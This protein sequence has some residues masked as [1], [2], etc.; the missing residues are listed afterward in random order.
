MGKT[1]GA[2]FH[3]S[4]DEIVQILEGNYYCGT[5]GQL[6]NHSY[7]YTFMQSTIQLGMQSRPVPGVTGVKRLAQG[8][9]S[10][11]TLLTAGFEPVTNTTW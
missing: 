6:N 2:K 8:P 10:D 9:N 1:L 5:Q 4:S 3:N 11:I 7:L